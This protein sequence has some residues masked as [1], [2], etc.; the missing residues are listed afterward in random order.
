MKAVYVTEYGAP[1]VL[2]VQEA[3]LPEPGPAQARIKVAA[4]SV[5]FA[6]IQSRRAPYRAG[7]TPPFL[8]GLEAAGTIDALGPG[9]S[10]FTVGQRVAVHAD[11]CSYAEYIL[12]KTIEIFPLPDDA[13][14]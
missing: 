5:N 2:K 10:G 3:P 14:L 8:P 6:D 1:E 9:V 12:A 4:T 7:V 13:D 11:G